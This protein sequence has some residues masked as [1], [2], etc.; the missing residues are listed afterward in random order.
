VCCPSEC[1]SV[2]LRNRADDRGAVETLSSQK[3]SRDF[4]T[5]RIEMTAGRS[6]ESHRDARLA[7]S[8]PL[9]HFG[10]VRGAGSADLQA[11][12]KS[13]YEARYG[14]MP[15]D[16][17]DAAAHL[18]VARDRAGKVVASLRVLTNENRPFSFDA[19]LDLSRVAGLGQAPAEIGRWCVDPNLRDVS[20]AQGLHFG[21]MKFVFLFAAA[22]GV[23]DYVI[24]IYP[25]LERFYRGMYFEDSGQGFDHPDWGSVR[26]FS[27]SLQ[28]VTQ[29]FRQ[30]GTTLGK[31][32]LAA[33][34]TNF[35]LS[36][37]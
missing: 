1:I 12:Q 31:F 24:C 6:T 4:A 10:V 14:S 30:S 17:R 3:P 29:R 28:R 2:S 7:V 26:L 8:E 13:V 23:S 11:F 15:D 37:A 16:G 5:C 27:M 36:G 19:V 33:P 35:S 32:I 20:G 25:E 18:L 22:R 9:Y 21:L 34:G